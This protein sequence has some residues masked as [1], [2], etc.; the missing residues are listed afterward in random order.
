[1]IL[2]IV[3]ANM[4]TDPDSSFC[5][6]SSPAEGAAQKA[7]TVSP[8]P[9][10]PPSTPSRRRP[11]AACSRP[12]LGDD[13]D[14]P[15][16]LDMDAS[17][18]DTFPDEDNPLGPFL[19]N[20]PSDVLRVVL[21]HLT[22]FERALFA[23]AG[24]ACYRAAKQSGL[25]RAGVS[26]RDIEQLV[27]RDELTASMSVFTWSLHNLGDPDQTVPCVLR[28]R[29]RVHHHDQCL[30]TLVVKS[31]AGADSV[32]I[33]AT[34]PQAKMRGAIRGRTKTRAPPPRAKADSSR[35]S[36]FAP[37]DVR[38]MRRRAIAQPKVN[39]STW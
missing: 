33:C 28:Y 24:G 29:T 34:R 9:L 3:C 4:L 31:A 27:K 10:L 11:A 21:G 20:L 12:S 23:R 17:V 13:P 19:G 25:G 5:V 38:G 32:D 8:R 30:G 26:S 6:S 16:L 18:R 35:S 36:G 37:T 7:T 14:R 39:T 15:P 2:V 1:M 22:P